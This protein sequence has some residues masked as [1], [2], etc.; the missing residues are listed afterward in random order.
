MNIFNF[1]LSCMLAVFSFASVAAD[2]TSPVRSTGSSAGSSTM[3]ASPPVITPQ[4]NPERSSKTSPPPQ[5]AAEDATQ[6][7]KPCKKGCSSARE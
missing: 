7:V 3:T 6:K 4:P 5:G 2:R 1:V